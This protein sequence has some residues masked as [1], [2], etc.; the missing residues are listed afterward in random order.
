LRN[1]PLDKALEETWKNKDKFYEGTKGLTMLE[2]VTG[3]ENKYNARGN[4]HNSVT[5]EAVCSDPRRS[6]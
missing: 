4:A 3:I 1:D 2:I 5:H 6:L